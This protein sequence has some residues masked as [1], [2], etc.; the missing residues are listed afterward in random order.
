MSTPDS[1][2]SMDY[3]VKA[4]GH[5]ATACVR[6]DQATCELCG[7]RGERLVEVNGVACI[8][9]CRCQM[10]PDRIRI[11]NNAQIP[12]RF[13][14]ASFESFDK[15]L[16][17][18]MPGFLAAYRWAKA[19]RPGQP[20]RSL[21]LHGA[22]GRGK[23]H[24]LTAVLRELVFQHGVSVRFVEFT[25]LLAALKKG[26]EHGQGQAQTLD[27]LAGVDVLA[28]D[29]LGKG[30]RTEWELAIVDELI[31]RRYNGMKVLLGTT[32]YTPGSATGVQANLAVDDA[33][34]TLGD[35]IGDRS[36]SRLME[37][38]DFE[39]VQGEDYRESAN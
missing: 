17:D 15:D 24:L 18:A 21:M 27:A 39:W 1:S 25:H 8:A 10:L 12:A 7:G 38:A 37:M 2:K 23:T 29:E 3:E 4:R 11:F 32:N 9:R 28:V 19:F 33:R 22:V 6:A 34:H 20:N 16:P 31:S 35:R 36:F 30:R 26:F 14:G 5:F 13:A